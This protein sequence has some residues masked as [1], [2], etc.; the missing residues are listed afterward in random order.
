MSV[1]L[2]DEAGG[3]ILVV[4]VSGTLTN[5]EYERYVRQ[6]ERL[7]KEHGK[8]RILCQMSNF[9]G[10]KAGSLR[11]DLEFDLKQLGD[12]ERLAVIHDKASEDGAA[13]FYKPYAA[14]EARYFDE[15]QAEEAR[16]WIYA[17]V[18]RF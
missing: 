10:W 2:H 18:P 7:I 5:P 14:A 1:E 15:S 16:Q 6:A 12:L 17:D 4:N 9:H 8:L 3:K 13:A 11:E